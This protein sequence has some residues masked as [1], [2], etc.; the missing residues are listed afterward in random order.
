MLI[1]KKLENKKIINVFLVKY[2]ENCLKSSIKICKIQKPV[3]N[4]PRDNVIKDNITLFLKT[5]N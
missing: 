1:K 2:Y 5:V 4:I 3:R